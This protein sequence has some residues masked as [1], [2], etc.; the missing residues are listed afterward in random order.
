MTSRPLGLATAAAL[1]AACS[2]QPSNSQPGPPAPA[3]PVDLAALPFNIEE[4]G[5][6]DSPWSM[7]FL[8]SGTILVSQ[9]KGEMILFDPAR[10]PW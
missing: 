2:S 1:M 7:A 9:K 8:P 4:K 5:V 6:F 3:E 10:P